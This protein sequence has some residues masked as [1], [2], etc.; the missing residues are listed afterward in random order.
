MTEATAKSGRIAADP[1]R[2]FIARLFTAAGMS[3]PD[4]ATVANVL[5]W[6]NLRGVDSHGVLRAPQYLEYTRN[7]IMDAKAEPTILRSLPAAALMDGARAAGPVAMT[8]AMN[9]AMALAKNTGIG[10]VTVRR[11]THT[12]PIGYYALMAARADMVGLVFS[13]STPNMAYF[14]ASKAGVSNA[15]LAIAVPAASHAPFVLDMAASVAASGKIKQA[16]DSGLPIPADWALGEDGKPTTDPAAVDILLPLGGP[17][18]SGLALMLECVTGLLSGA[19]A[20]ERM[21]TGKEPRR[22]RQNAMVIAIDIAAF[23][24]P[25]AFREDADALASAIKGLPR[26]ADGDDILMPGERGART[27]AERQKNGIPLPRGTWK[28]LSDAA[29]KFGVAMPDPL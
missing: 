12:G 29:A 2:T 17:K 27:E 14:G 21:L 22:H 11:T 3:E 8:R 20:I 7:G 19:P 4:A 26:L 9:H 5:V 15:P 13:T 10:M 1:L 6:A 28:R 23:T 24:D 25:A 18:G 16:L